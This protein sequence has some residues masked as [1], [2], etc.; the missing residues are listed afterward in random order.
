MNNKL[1]GLSNNS[2]ELRDLLEAHL[3]KPEKV[4]L[5]ERAYK[6]FDVNGHLNFSLSWSWWAFFGGPFYFFYRKLYLIGIIVLTVGFVGT[7]IWNML[8]LFGSIVCGLIAKFFYIQKFRNDLLLS[9]YGEISPSEVKR[10]L[11]ILGGYNTWAIW[12]YFVGLIIVTVLVILIM[13]VLIAASFD[14][15]F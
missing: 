9:R 12:A 6:K 7:G 4:D 1:D 8:G 15:T 14:H 5:F 10:Y 11:T 3:Q 13:G 2:D